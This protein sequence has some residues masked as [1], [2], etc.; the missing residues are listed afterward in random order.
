MELKELIES[1][2]NSNLEGEQLALNLLTSEEVDEDTKINY[3]HQF[4]EKFKKD[5]SYYQKE[6]TKVL[7]QQWLDLYSEYLIPIV[8]NRLNKI[9]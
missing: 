5:Q 3:V 1:L 7:L 8:K 2:V 6:E 9:S 4:F